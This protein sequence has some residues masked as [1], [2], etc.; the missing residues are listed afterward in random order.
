MSQDISSFSKLVYIGVRTD[1]QT[2]T[3]FK[4]LLDIV[5]SEVTDTTVRSPRNISHVYKALVSLNSKFSG[6][7]S[8]S[9][10]SFPDQYFTCQSTCQSCA[11][12]CCKQIKHT[13][14][15]C[16][17][18]TVQCTYSVQLEN[19]VY[20]CRYCQ[21]NGRR[22]VVVPKAAA[23]KESSWVGLAKFAWSGFVLECQRCGVI[24]RSRQQWFGNLDPETQG[25]VQ[26]HVAHVWPGV[27]VLVTYLA[28]V[29]L[30]VIVLYTYLAH[31][32][33]GFSAS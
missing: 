2:R 23:S 32:W 26:T 16:T 4:P 1:M 6:D 28:H 3:C 19:K 24:Y 30:G 8:P 5:S 14:D 31:V 17:D 21:D 33:L 15:H 7:V 25:V 27:S 13:G 9:H 12:R 22:C 11:G 10:R 18:T 29:L 20:T